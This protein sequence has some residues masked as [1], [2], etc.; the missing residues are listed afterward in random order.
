MFNKNNM[1]VFVAMSGG[2]DSS[3]AAMLL[4]EKG[5]DVT[6]VFM[7][8]WHA[9]IHDGFMGDC[10]WQDDWQDVQAVCKILKIPCKIWDFSKEYYEEVVSYFIKDRSWLNCILII[11]IFIIAD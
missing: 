3:V 9:D 4:R 2:V 8:N 5:Y 10:P 6:G 1:K 11:H 7:R